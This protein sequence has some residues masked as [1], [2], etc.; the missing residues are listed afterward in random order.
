MA[1]KFTAAGD[2]GE[3]R[4][5]FIVC[6][7]CHFFSF[8]YHHQHHCLS[9]FSFCYHHQHH[10]YHLV[11]PPKCSEFKSVPC[12]LSELHIPC[13]SLN[14]ILQDLFRDTP[15]DHILRAQICTQIC[16]FGIFGHIWHIW[17]HIFSGG[18]SIL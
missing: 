5:R 3:S 18:S 8:C 4:E 17:V 16:I 2:S 11:E 9:L 13:K 1:G 14:C 10:H 15:L 7:L 6:H 12:L